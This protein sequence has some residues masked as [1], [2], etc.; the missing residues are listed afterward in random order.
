MILLRIINVTLYVCSEF[1][2]HGERDR[3]IDGWMDN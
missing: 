1:V 3:S 2:M